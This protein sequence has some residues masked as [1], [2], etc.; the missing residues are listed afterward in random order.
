MHD[1][2]T[3]I[4]H[5]LIFHYELI[6]IVVL[7]DVIS[8]NYLTLPRHIETGFPTRFDSLGKDI[9]VPLIQVSNLTSLPVSKCQPTTC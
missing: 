4:F 8:I 6:I 7:A 1:T 9:P 2:N 5:S 3:V